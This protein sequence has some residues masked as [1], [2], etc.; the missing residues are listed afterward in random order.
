MR[1]RGIVVVHG[2][3]SQR[4]GQTLNDIGEPLTQY[5]RYYLDPHD[6]HV[7]DFEV[8]LRPDHGP[9]NARLR[10]DHAGDT[11]LWTITEAW[12]AES[13]H[14]AQSDAVLLWGWRILLR[15]AKN[16]FFGTL[17]RHVPFVKTH[18][19][20]AGAY[21]YGDVPG[22]GKPSRIYDFVVSVVLLGFFL[23][24]YSLALALATLL[25]AV[26]Q[27]PPWLLV[28][29][30]AARLQRWLI[31]TLLYGPGDEHALI[32]NNLARSSASGTV[33]ETLAPYLNDRRPD[34]AY[35]DSVSI[36]A[37]SGGAVV[38]YIALSDQ[39][40]KNWSFGETAERAR[41][42]VTWFSVGSGLNLGFRERKTDP[43]WRREL[44]PRIRWVDLWARH[45]PVPHG[46]ADHEMTRLIRAP[47]APEDTAHFVSQRVVNRDN[48]FTDHGEYWRNYEEVVSRFVYETLVAPDVATALGQAVQTSIGDIPR[49]RRA[50][51][52]NFVAARAAA[53]IVVAAG[54]LIGRGLLLGEAVL[55]M[56]QDIALPW[57]L[58]RLISWLGTNPRLGPLDLNAMAGVIVLGSLAYFLYR[59]YTL[60]CRAAL[61]RGNVFEAR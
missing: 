50:I 53:A 39:E 54:F 23:V 61:E 14:P 25:F 1:R 31:D 28:A 9:A 7:L 16:I 10:F 35:C 37:H 41:T 55:G 33:I 8:D 52:R 38:S 60:I 26:A 57:P 12:W 56:L 20:P 47:H 48:P 24:G 51:A 44:D 17:G 22:G 42:S 4:K 11:E 19:H 21:P 3:G 34:Y 43:L 27:L 15:Q 59:L 45:D 6:P 49:H 32:K 29:E 18:T 2:V 30:P 13:F 36:I 46:Q 5:L 58:D 40:I